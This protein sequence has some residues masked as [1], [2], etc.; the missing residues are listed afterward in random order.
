MKDEGLLW[1]RRRRVRGR[2]SEAGSLRLEISHS[3]EGADWTE[4]VVS[5]PGMLDRMKF[6]EPEITV[7]LSAVANIRNNHSG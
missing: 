6:V 1:K 3:A 7:A 2:K 4:V 5:L